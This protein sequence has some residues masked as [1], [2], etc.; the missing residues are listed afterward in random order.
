MNK[1]ELGRIILESMCKEFKENEMPAEIYQQNVAG[2]PTDILR[3]MY[4]DDPDEKYGGIAEYTF[5]DTAISSKDILYLSGY[6]TLRTNVDRDRMPVILKAVARMNF[7]LP[8]GSVLVN[9]TAGF[10]ALRLD[11]R[12]PAMMDQKTIEMVA[13]T[14]CA[15][16]V[17]LAYHCAKPIVDL[18]DGEISYDEYADII[19]Q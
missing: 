17:E 14:N 4:S 3:V 12:I 16:L 5:M 10:V 15:H 1:K 11:T 7:M 19:E 6:I 13:N 8:F 2:T 18:I 9:E